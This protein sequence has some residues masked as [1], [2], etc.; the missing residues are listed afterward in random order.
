MAAKSKSEVK[1]TYV[2][3]N[4][5]YNTSMYCM[6]LNLLTSCAV[7][8]FFWFHFFDQKVPSNSVQNSN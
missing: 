4:S 1:L 2:G 3:F 5:I 6:D 8:Y 7:H